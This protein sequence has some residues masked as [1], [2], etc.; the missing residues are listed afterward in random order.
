MW[1]QDA[2]NGM[3]LFLGLKG[4]GLRPIEKISISNLYPLLLPNLSEKQL[5][6]LLD[7]YD[8]CFDTDI[9]EYPIP[10]APP[11]DPMTFKPNRDYDPHH[12]E[13]DRLDRGSSWIDDN[14]N[15]VERG[16]RKQA[17]RLDMQHRLDLV[18]RCSERAERIAGKSKELIKQGYFE[19]YDP[20]TGEPQRA[21]RVQNFAWSTLADIM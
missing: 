4:R 18:S 19:F 12:G 1:N 7:L 16:F 17:S 15:L 2:A 13:A 11:I 10:T 6:S 8:I 21:E 9:I 20:E 14:F 3:G 5:E